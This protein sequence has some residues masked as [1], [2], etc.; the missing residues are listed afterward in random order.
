VRDW[1]IRGLRFF[2]KMTSIGW[3]VLVWEVRVMVLVIAA[4]LIWLLVIGKPTG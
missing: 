4:V 2:D 1:V 3:S